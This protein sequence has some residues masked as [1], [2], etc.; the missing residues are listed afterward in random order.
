[1]FETRRG[2]A[3]T[4]PLLLGDGVLVLKPRRFKW[5]DL[6]HSLERLSPPLSS[7]CGLL[8][9]RPCGGSRCTWQCGFS[10]VKVLL[11]R[12]F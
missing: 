11:F 3:G 6:P 12:G 5:V 7:G 8:A 1:M 4:H 9:A 10:M 2:G